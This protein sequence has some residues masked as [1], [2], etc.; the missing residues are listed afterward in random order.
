MCIE[1]RD[2]K[3]RALP[4]NSMH[5]PLQ[6]LELPTKN[7]SS[8]V[9]STVFARSATAKSF[10]FEVWQHS[11]V[12]A[13]VAQNSPSEYPPLLENTLSPTHM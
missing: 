9:G 12:V 8:I 1:E 4:T 11:G 7:E 13:V 10:S 3:D 2:E 5:A 6:T